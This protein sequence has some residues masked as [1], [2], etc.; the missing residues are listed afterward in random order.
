MIRT[1]AT[2]T[3]K[4]TDR[5]PPAPANAEHK[6]IQAVSGAESIAA[7]LGRLG[8]LSGD[9]LFVHA[10]LSSFDYIPGGTR[11]LMEG[12]LQAVGPS[13]TLVFPTLTGENSDP[14]RWKAPPVASQDI[15]RQIL[16]ATP[17]FDPLLSIPWKRVGEL[18]LMATLWPGA[19]RSFH[20][21]VSFTAIGKRAE[22]ICDG[23]GDNLDHPL[24]QHGVLG[25]L[26]RAEA[27]VLFLGTAWKTCTALHLVEHILYDPVPD[28]MCF[29]E[30]AVIT[31]NGVRCYANY[32]M[33]T[34]TTTDFEA[35]GE[36]LEK[37]YPEAFAILPGENNRRMLLFPM[38]EIID[39]ATPLMRISRGL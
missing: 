39:H 6:P 37:T 27:R 21:Q 18:P 28:H 30:T 22:E 11:S 15:R 10:A 25:R 4:F 5:T 38:K 12:L 31:S 34:Q 17:P 33:F 2:L 3:L 23:L 19:I 29:E 26:Y 35:I 36:S 8:V 14:V 7:T 13:G 20:P 1:S 32:R 9:L 16:E 24:S